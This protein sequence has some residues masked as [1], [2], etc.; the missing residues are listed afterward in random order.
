M[1]SETFQSKCQED[2]SAFHY[3]DYFQYLSDELRLLD[4]FLLRG[5]RIKQKNTQDYHSTSKGFFIPEEEVISL[6]DPSQNSHSNSSDDPDIEI[7]TKLIEKV[8]DGIASRLANTAN[9]IES[10]PLLR[11]ARIF[12]L[13]PFEREVLIMALAAEIDKKYERIYAYFNDDMTKKLPSMSIALD[14]LLGNGIDKLSGWRSF[15]PHAPLLHFHLIDLIDDHGESSFLNHR[16]R[17]DERIKRYIAADNGPHA[18]LSGIVQAHYPD[19]AVPA[20]NIQKEVQERVLQVLAEGKRGNALHPVFWLYGKAAEEKKAIALAICEQVKLPLLAADLEDL[21]LE[22]DYKSIVKT[23][24]RE[25]ALQPAALFI[26]GGD[27]LYGEDERSGALRR[28]LLRA[29]NEM[30]WITFISAESLWIPEENEGQYQWY[31][32]EFK[33]PEYAERRGIWIKNLNGSKLS[34][35]D[36]DSLSARFNFGETQIRNAVSCAK[37]FTNGNEL[38]LDRILDA[39][40][41][42][43]NQKLSIY[44]TKVRPHYTWDDIVLPD[45]K[46]QQL[47]E[48]CSYIKHKQLVYFKW[49]FEEKLA[50][51]RGL[52]ILFSGASGTG[53]T[54]AADIIANALKLEMVKVDLSSVVSKYI[55]ETEKNLN[56][57]FRGTSAGNIIL[58]FDE[59]DALFGKRTEVKDAHDRYA[60]I[61][62]NYLLQ[63]MEEH[64][65]I[66]ILATNLSKNLDEAFLRRMHF[67]IEFPFP[68]EKRREL[69]WRKIF[70]RG[71]PLSEDVDYGF[72]SERFKVA[73]GNIRNMAL[74]AAFYAAEDSSAIRMEHIILAVQR[75]LQKMGKLCVKGDFGMYYQLIEERLKHE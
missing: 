13:T 43:S 74:A 36:I 12:G 37:Q 6:L 7:T 57:I 14:I 50:L 15:S 21:F 22:S 10:Y 72:I 41:I 18:S 5:L 27:R 58:F 9:H 28:V 52:N 61:E 31:P 49:G 26:G 65:G 42:Q 47:K 44:T 71:A 17:L 53:K 35:S 67:S 62:I 66:V 64:E 69:I 20:C 2:S 16:F 34:E 23:L 55:G 40:R 30:S 38:T 11:L 32:F 1:E 4:L 48:I 24:F 59:A 75:E 60:N 19:A 25:A 46:V 63:K 39:C 73:G 51:G 68:D 45:D 70:P 33:A 8:R 54:M 29:I 56:R 3:E